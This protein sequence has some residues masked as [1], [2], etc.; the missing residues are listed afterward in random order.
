[1]NFGLLM[2][3]FIDHF[4]HR[5]GFY[6]T[7]TTNSRCLLMPDILSVHESFSDT[8]PIIVLLIIILTASEMLLN[9]INVLYRSDVFSL[10]Q[11]SPTYCSFSTT[12]CIF[13]NPGLSCVDSWISNIKNFL[14]YPNVVKPWFI[15]FRWTKNYVFWNF[16]WGK[17][18]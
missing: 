16:S 13:L 14:F 5:C 4:K 18:N 1:M 3:F 17:N 2:I 12:N 15:L 11:K 7:Q 8:L 10:K 9:V 6:L